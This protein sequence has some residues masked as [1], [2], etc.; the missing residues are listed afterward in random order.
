MLRSLLTFRSLGFTVIP[1]L[2]PLPPDLP[3]G[4]KAVMVFYE[5]MG[6]VSYGLR[7]RYFPQSIPVAERPQIAVLEN[8]LTLSM[9]V[10]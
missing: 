5:Y 9:Q 8:P 2:S 4:K 7:G 3:Q 1:H 6:L 10:A